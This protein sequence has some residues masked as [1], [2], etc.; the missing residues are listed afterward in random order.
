MILMISILAFCKTTCLSSIFDIIKPPYKPS[1][2]IVFYMCLPLPCA[3]TP[4]YAIYP[5][6]IMLMEG[7][8]SAILFPRHFS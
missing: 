6:T 5:T 8:I 3:F 7:L 1:A 4:R 2:P